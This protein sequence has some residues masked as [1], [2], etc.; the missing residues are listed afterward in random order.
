MNK[1]RLKPPAGDSY[2]DGKEEEWYVLFF[3]SACSES[4]G[5]KA[6]VQCH[7]ITWWANSGQVLVSPALV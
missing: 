3:S 1:C 7:V 2:K 5:S 4:R 6:Q